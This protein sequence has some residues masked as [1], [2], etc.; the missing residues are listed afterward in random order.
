MTTRTAYITRRLGI[1]LAA[2]V[3]LAT[4]GGCPADSETVIFIELDAENTMRPADLL[5]VTGTNGGDSFTETYDI[6]GE[7]FPISFTV[8]PTGRSGTVAFD[9]SAFS[10]NGEEVLIRGSVSGTATIRPNERVNLRLTLTPTDFVVNS[11]SVGAQTITSEAES[12]GKQ[13]TV[14]PDGSFMITFLN[15]CLV[16]S[17]CDVY[18]RR[19]D[20]NTV[21]TP[22]G[23][24]DNSSEF[25]VNLAPISLRTGSP[26]TT[27]GDNGV[28]V[29]WPAAN[30][31]VLATLLDSNSDPVASDFDL[32]PPATPPHSKPHAAALGDGDFVAVWVQDLGASDKRIVGSFIDE[33][34]SVSPVTPFEVS[35][36]TGQRYADPTVAAIDGGR[37]FVV[38]WHD[39][40]NVF[41]RFFDST[42]NPIG[43]G[44]TNLTEY[45]SDELTTYGPHVAWVGDA[46]M[47]V[48]G[49]FGEPGFANGSVLMRRFDMAGEPSG[50][51]SVV[52]PNT[53]DSLAKPAITAR[54]DGTVAVA[55]HSC[56]GQGDGS[57][58]GIFMQV[59]HPT[60]LPIG[61]IITANTTDNGDQTDAS[62]AA[63][64]DDAFLVAWTDDSKARPDDS[65]TAVRA[66]VIYPGIGGDGNGKIGATC[67][68]AGDA[69]CESGLVCIA[70]SDSQPHCHKACTPGV[71]PECPSGG[72]CQRLSGDQ[73]GCVF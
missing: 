16:R 51:E 52:L 39:L 55:W 58:C 2:G 22:N 41:A 47:V 60:G 32:A 29:I 43:T 10:R 26:V 6:D 66:R 68:G 31:G 59:A 63:M 46:A 24:S 25:F 69:P 19:F 12:N 49:A 15:D 67:G 11:S 20:T 23:V 40:S 7:P 54:D 62:I 8:T 9:I 34:G 57:G 35:T 64:Q 28:L 48:W 13:V 18:A 70:G 50:A 33:V 72:I 36:I 42:G 37:G 1:V 4:L 56:G 3:F 53:V 21:P 38:V 71:L 73:A 30:G 61:D 5:E 27:S 44:E 17:L 45:N 65:G 14:L